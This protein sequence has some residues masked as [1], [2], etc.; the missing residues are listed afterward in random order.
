[1]HWLRDKLTSGLNYSVGI[2]S[3]KEISASIRFLPIVV[4]RR[5]QN[6][7]SIGILENISV[8]IIMLIAS[9]DLFPKYWRS[10]KYSLKLLAPYHL[11]TSDSER[12]DKNSLPL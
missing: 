11:V 8:L 6:P 10:R 1:M 2:N 5:R 9:I 4:I 7:D 3:P 12:Y